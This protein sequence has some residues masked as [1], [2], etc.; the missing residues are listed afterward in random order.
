MGFFKTLIRRK[1]QKDEEEVSDFGVK[2]EKPISRFNSDSE[3]LTFIR[4]NCE[5][6]T[7]CL[8]QIEEAKMEYQA[9]TSYLTD[10]Q[11][12]DMVPI[13]Q[14][15]S[16][17][18][19]A[20]NIYNL[21]QE[22]N[23]LKNKSSI[24]TDSQYRL[25]EQYEPVILKDLARIISSEEYLVKIEQD[26]KKLEKERRKLDHEQED[27][28]NKQ[29]FLKGM[30]TVISVMV[31]ILFLM[32][33]VLSSITEANYTIPFMMTVLMGMLSALYIILEARKNQINIRLVQ[34]KLNRQIILANKV[35][36]KAVNN[37][38]YLDYEYSK[39]NVENGDQLKLYWEEYVKIKEENRKYLKNTQLLDFHNNE[40]IRELKK[41]GV[42]DAEIW[43][44]QPLAILDNKEMVEV[45]HRLNIRRQKLRERIDLNAKQKEDA[46]NEIKAIMEKYPELA[47]E[48]EKLLRRYK[49][50]IEQDI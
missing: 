1:K 4:D 28:T 42:A 20:K 24:L 46:L 9:V 49:L 13:E 11:K 30:A 32:F 45:R 23:K 26:M 29:S 37:R 18:D 39:Y 17:E 44:F 43:I 14:R 22:R 38:N 48:G 41:F 12:I 50:E 16:M 33:L 34:S 15:G 27:I 19:A 2:T 8:R 25:L 5:Q 35:K 6:I 40:L 36:I 7:E 21:T 47:H 31:A 10:I 3:R